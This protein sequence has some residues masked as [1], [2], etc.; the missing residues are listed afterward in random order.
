ML[1]FLTAEK[2][3]EYFMRGVKL[4]VSVIAVCCRVKKP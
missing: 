2:A 4:A 3:V 1:N